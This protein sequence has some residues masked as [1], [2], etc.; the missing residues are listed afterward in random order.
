MEYNL[1]GVH[2]KQFGHFVVALWGLPLVLGRSRVA[3]H[4]GI[5]LPS[6]LENHVVTLETNRKLG[7]VNF[8][9]DFWDFY[10]GPGKQIGR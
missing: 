2:Q 10:W 3:S 5:F 1:F 4:Y 9:K 6:F 8:G 7:R